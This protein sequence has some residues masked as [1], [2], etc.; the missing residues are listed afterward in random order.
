MLCLCP[1]CS[2]DFQQLRNCEGLNYCPKCHNLFLAPPERQMPPWILGV[3]TVLV[4]NWQ[5]IVRHAL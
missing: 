4:I 3:L 5:I 2:H 1:K